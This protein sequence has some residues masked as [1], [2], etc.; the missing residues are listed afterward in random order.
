[1][2]VGDADESGAVEGG[3]DGGRVPGAV[4]AE[5][6]GGG[7]R[8]DR[9]SVDVDAGVGDADGDTEGG[10]GGGCRGTGGGDG[11]AVGRGSRAG[12][13]VGEGGL[14]CGGNGGIVDE[15]G[16]WLRRYGRGRL[17]DR[18]RATGGRGEAAGGGG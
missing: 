3:G 1:M 4:G 6:E 17:G 10:V 12:E 14:R 15:F 2:I 5:L 11:G 8:G 13:V 9:G 18:Y 7:A 16:P